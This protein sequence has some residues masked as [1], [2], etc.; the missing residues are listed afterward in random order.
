MREYSNPE[1]KITVSSV[2]FKYYCRY[3]RVKISRKCKSFISSLMPLNLFESSHGD[4][5]FLRAIS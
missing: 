5:I 1:K 2:S 4:D 3:V